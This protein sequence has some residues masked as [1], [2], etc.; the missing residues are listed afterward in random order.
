MLQKTFD[1]QVLGPDQEPCPL[2]EAVGE[3][4]VGGEAPVGEVEGSTF[5]EGVPVDHLA[6]GGSLVETRGG[7]DDR[8]GVHA[9]G[10]AEGGGEMEFVMPVRQGLVGLDEGQRASGIVKQTHAG[11]VDGSQDKIPVVQGR[12]KMRVETVEKLPESIRKELFPLLDVS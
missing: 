6:E 9:V 10:D 5:A 11:A 2:F 12:V 4:I 3:D 1:V 7:L 8:V